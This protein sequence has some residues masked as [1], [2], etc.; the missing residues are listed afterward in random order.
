MSDA[1]LNRDQTV[2]REQQFFDENADRYRR[3]R[4]RITRAIGAFN[5]SAEVHDLYDPVGKRVLDYGCGEGRFTFELL[6]RGASDVTGFDISTTRIEAANRR[7]GELGLADR[8]RFLVADAHDTG[9]PAGSF[10]LIIGS[11]ILHHLDLATA[12]SEL[13]RLLAPGGT[14]IFV[15]PLAHHP[16]LRLGRRL[17]PAARTDDEHPLT[18]ADWKLLDGAFPRFEH[19][20]REF[21]TIPL[22]PLNLVL[23]TRLSE[24]LASRAAAWD[25]RALERWPA[26][27]KYSRRTL[28]SMGA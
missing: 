18:E 26:L 4:G 14:A 10:D 27:R 8:A 19:Q 13:R 3:V 15:E 16:L 25:D 12:A 5:R 22:M 24:R 6:R 7:A 28:L 9:L 2:A 20:E 23:P 21:V 1:G 11:D 17:T